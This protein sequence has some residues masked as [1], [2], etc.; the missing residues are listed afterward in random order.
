MTRKLVGVKTISAQ[1]L[2]FKCGSRGTQSAYYDT[3]DGFLHNEIF[4]DSC[5]SGRLEDV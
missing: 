4:C 1:A 3:G 5:F 2:C